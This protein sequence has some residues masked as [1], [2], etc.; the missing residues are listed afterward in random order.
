M[1]GKR[2][3][4]QTGKGNIRI[5]SRK[6]RRYKCKVCGRTLRET[7][8]TLFHGLK[9]DRVTVTLVLMLLAWGCPRIAIV[10]A[11]GID[12]RTVHE[13]LRR[14]SAQCEAVHAHRV[15]AQPLDLVHVQAD[16]IKVKLQG[17]SV[18]M[19]LA[20]MVPTRLW[21]GGVV[22]EQR[23]LTL[24][25]QLFAPLRT[26]AHSQPLLVCVDGFRSYVKVIRKTFRSPLPRHGQGGRRKWVAWPN[27]VIA[28]VIKTRLVRGLDLSQ[29]IVQGSTEQVAALLARSKGGTQINTA[30]IERLNATFRQRLAPPARRT[31]CPAQ[32]TQT[33]TAGMWLLGTFYNFCT[34]HESLSLAPSEQSN[35]ARTPAM[36]AGLTDHVWTPQELF[37]LPIPPPR[38]SPPKAKG[39][40]SIATRRLVQEW[41]SDSTA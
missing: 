20:L 29:R 19:A 14:A 21:L 17:C 36:A 15:M 26:L 22:R 34:P 10:K 27:S 9:T 6:E 41:C 11:F 31:R 28:Q 8:G 40:P 12:E 4:R 30:Y 23:D 37:A 32:K 39:R 25:Q 38:W 5:H 18:W 7:R 1:S 33:L 2:T 35:R 3:N 24:I 13:W 16:E